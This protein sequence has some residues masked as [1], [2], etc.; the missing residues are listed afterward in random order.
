[1][2]VVVL[3]VQIL[4]LSLVLSIKVLVLSLVLGI[5]L[6][7]E[8]AMLPPGHRLAVCCPMLSVEVLMFS[9][10]LS[11]EV[12]VLSLMLGVQ[13]LMLSPVLLILIMG[14]DNR[15]SEQHAGEW[16]NGKGGFLQ[17]GLHTITSN[18]FRT[19]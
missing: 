19:L 5:E 9:L 7:V 8:S 11:I 14:K 10:M 12:L 1:V 17:V 3:G 2:I 18:V 6:T 15:C 16:K 4:V 13:A